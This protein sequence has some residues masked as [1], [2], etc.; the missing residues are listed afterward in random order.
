MS[1]IPTTLIVCCTQFCQIPLFVL[2]F[3]KIKQYAAEQ[4]VFLFNPIL[5]RKDFYFIEMYK[6]L[7]Y[8]MWSSIEFD[9]HCEVKLFSLV[10]HQAGW[11]LVWVAFLFQCYSYTFI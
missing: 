6:M 9:G 5:S 11:R 1:E 7:L 10:V 2:K 4:P 3:V 8:L